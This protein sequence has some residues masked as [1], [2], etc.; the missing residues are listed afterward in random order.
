MVILGM[1][2]EK[3]LIPFADREEDE[4][5]FMLLNWW[6]NMPLVLVSARYMQACFGKVHFLKN[7]L[8]EIRPFKR[9][10]GL[11]GECFFDDGGGLEHGIS[12]SYSLGDDDEQ[13]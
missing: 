7:K 13:S 11:V 1:W 5:Y 8:T 10:E 6:R 3:K 4:Y 9:N 12:M 2:K